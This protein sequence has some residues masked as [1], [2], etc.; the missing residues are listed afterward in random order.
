[1]SVFKRRRFAVE[2]ILLRVRWYCKCAIS[3]RDLAGIMRERGVDFGHTT[4][5]RWVQRHAPEIGK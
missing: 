1:M 3:Y 2:I 5:F 4:L